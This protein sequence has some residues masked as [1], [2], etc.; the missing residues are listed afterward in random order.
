[1]W[2]ILLL[3]KNSKLYTSLTF[4]LL[5]AMLITCNKA[6][7]H[8]IPNKN[9]PCRE[10]VCV[11][12]LTQDGN[13][14]IANT[15]NTLF[16]ISCHKPHPHLCIQINT[17]TYL[18]T[19]QDQTYINVIIIEILQSRVSKCIVPQLQWNSAGHNSDNTHTHTVLYD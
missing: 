19:N 8:V 7:F 4:A 18:G 5:S 6:N 9:M 16:L 15:T 1:M 3:C 2:K 10:H 12:L 13:I 11:L 14:S 17:C